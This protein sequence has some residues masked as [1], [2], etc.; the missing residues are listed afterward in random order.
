MPVF[1]GVIVVISLFVA[2]IALCTVLVG[3]GA[4]LRWRI[5]LLPH[6]RQS[7]DLRTWYKRE[8]VKDDDRRCMQRIAFGMVFLIVQLPFFI[9]MEQRSLPYRTVLIG[10][11]VFLLLRGVYGHW[12]GGRARLAHHVTDKASTAHH[13]FDLLTLE[14]GAR[15]REMMM[16]MFTAERVIRLGGYTFVAASFVAALA[17]DAGA[18]GALPT[19]V[20]P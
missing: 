9:F 19:V 4:W 15:S 8:K 6:M 5:S 10:L 2:A 16:R 3:L 1:L 13:A 12:L 7:P 14:E 11:A 20:L 17:W 18:G